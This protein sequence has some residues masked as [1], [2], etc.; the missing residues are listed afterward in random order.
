MSAPRN[1]TRKLLGDHLLEGDLVLGEEMDLTVDQILI[2]DAT[3]S[4]TALQFEALG[5]DSVAVPLAVMYVDHNVLQIDD[6]NMDEHRFLQSFSSHY[7][8]QYSR[9]GNGISHYVH[10]ERFARPGELLVGADSHS[11]MAG[12]VGMFA[13]G[14]GGLDVAVAMAG[15]GFSLECP[16]VVGVELRGELPSWVQAKDIILELLRR[17]GVRGGVGR[18]FEFTGEGVPTLSV[19]DRGTICNMITELGATAAVFPSDAQ[20]SEWL[21]AQRREEDY[22]PLAADPDASY[23]ENE[24]IELPQLEPLIAEPSSPGNVVPVREVAGTRTVQVCVGS[25]VNSSYEDLATAAAVLRE[26]IVHPRIEMTVTPGSRQILDT[27]SKSGV[28]QD[29]VA[30]GARML[31]PVC[32]PCIGVGQ[33]PSSGVPSVRTFNR[34][35]PGRSGTS[36]DE[37]YLCSPATAAATALKGEISDPRELGKPPTIAPA[38]SDPNMDDRQILDPPPPEEARNVEIVR[39]PNI[40]PPPEGRPLPEELEG[41]IVI[42][43]EDDVSTGDMAPDGALGMSL[44]SNIPEC[45]KYMFRRQDPEFHDRALEWVGGFIVGGHNYGQGSSRE[46]AALAALHLGIRAVIARSFARIHRRNL[47]SQSILPLLF[48]EEDDYERVS[49]G[50]TWK[51]EGVRELIAAG[52]QTL[53]VHTDDGTKIELEIR[54]SPR[55]REVLMAGGTLKFLH[56]A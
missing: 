50:D 52:E 29:L 11:T 6:K 10:L 41:R 2:E 40:V 22:V 34:N 9:P 36:G 7:G 56:G 21:A 32:G 18:V 54:L 28:Y 35:F 14:A 25:S 24:V 37:V 5:A 48:R 17:Y 13:V 1:L 31:E 43:I 45:A 8:I 27:I 16:K 44:W 38:P 49:Q 23:D 26:N 42:V 53:V 15:Y 30:A 33:A 20:T 46:H 19:T 55:E 3:G 47:I 4:M 12:A 39:G 51:I